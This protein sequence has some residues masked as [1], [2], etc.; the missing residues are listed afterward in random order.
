MGVFD[1]IKDIIEGWRS[2]RSGEKLLYIGASNTGKSSEV[3]K[4]VENFNKKRDLLKNSRRAKKDN[5]LK[6]CVLDGHKRLSKFIRE[7]DIILNPSM[8]DWIDKLKN[9]RDSMVILDDHKQILGENDPPIE[10]IQFLFDCAE[11]GVDVIIITHGFKHVQPKLFDYFDKFCL[12]YFT[13]MDEALNR[14]G[15][16]ELFLDLKEMVTEE[17]RKFT[18]DEYTNLYP[19]FPYIYYDSREQ[20]IIKINF[21]QKQ[22]KW[23]RK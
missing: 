20:K 2:G 17:Y 7:G 22:Q 16:K 18:P 1:K 5:Y 23:E 4:K 19:N 13:G 11:N 10:F 8:D 9:L 15:N 21:N 12:W 3:C 14:T 6:L